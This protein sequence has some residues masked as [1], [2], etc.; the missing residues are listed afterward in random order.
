MSE[1]AQVKVE[2]EERAGR[3]LVATVTLD[4]ARRA[5]SLNS[6]LMEEFAERVDALADNPDLRIMV[7]TGAGDRSFCAGA[8]VLELK[9]LDAAAGRAF[10]TRVHHMSKVIRALPVPVIARVNGVCIGAGVE[11]MAACD[12]RVAVD[13]ATFSMP[14]VAIG[15]PSV[16]EAA[17]FPQL[18]GWGRT[19]QFLY[20]A[21]A[22][23]ASQAQSWGLVQEVVPGSG[24]DAAVAALVDPIVAADGAAIRRQKSLIRS[25]ESMSFTDGI[26]E[27][28]RS[29]TEAC[30]GGGHRQLI[31]ALAAGLK[32][33]SA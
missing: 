23:T 6:D 4:N 12:V 30:Q 27:G 20:T 16:V 2:L 33:K 28:I 31:E 29:F 7:L 18:I 22:I 8:N 21:E 10:I 24:L 17:L 19:K 13:T 5:N 26:E 32:S 1:S 15:L 9:S 14:E 25:W 11:V 3:G